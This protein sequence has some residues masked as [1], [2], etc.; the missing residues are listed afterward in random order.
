MKKIFFLIFSMIAIV[1]LK[2]VSTFASASASNSNSAVERFQDTFVLY[3]DDD[4]TIECTLITETYI[5]NPIR[6]LSVG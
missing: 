1:I 4:V 6:S 3:Q 5:A 2:P